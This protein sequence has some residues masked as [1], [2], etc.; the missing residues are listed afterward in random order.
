DPNPVV[1]FEHK[2]LYWSKVPGTT[3]A[4]SV[5]PAE[6]YV[7]PFGKAQLVR[8]I[9]EQQ[10]TEALS[11]VTY[12][13]GVHWAVNAVEELGLQKQIEIVDLRTLH[14][15][16]HKTVFKSVK[17][18]SKCLVVTEEPSENSF[19]RALQGKVQEACFQ[20]LDAPVMLIGA[21]NMPAIPLNSVLEE[22]IIP[23]AEKVKKKIL[24][25]LGY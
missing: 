8:E 10:G 2:G 7:L 14:P 15:L 22:T 1:I 17:K 18:C 9:R 25:I 13:M 19:G 20:Y 6:D 16:D 21:E 24:E 12:G 4:T 23:S 3:G 5:V 11:I